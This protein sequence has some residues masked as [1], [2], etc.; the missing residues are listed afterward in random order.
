MEQLSH[1]SC[2]LG[3]QFGCID[4]NKAPEIWVAG[5][6]R[7]LFEC[8]G[9]PNVLC[10]SQGDDV[11][12]R[13]NVTCSCNPPA[14]QVWVRPLAS[15]ASA[16]I[17]VLLVNARDKAGDVTLHFEDVHGWTG[18]TVAEVR[19]L[20]KRADVGSVTGRYHVPVVPPHG[21]VFL[22]LDKHEP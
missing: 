18:E 4:S 19:D 15:N 20:W 16:S 6:C 11:P 7:A 12:S 17:A 3:Q 9:T 8:Y 14:P 10:E 22:R 13:N 2:V 1:G 21:S 5:G